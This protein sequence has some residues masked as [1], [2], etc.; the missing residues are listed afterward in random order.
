MNTINTNTTVRSDTPVVLKKNTEVCG[1]RFELST[2][3]KGVKDLQKDLKLLDQVKSQ[4]NHEVDLQDILMK[5]KKLPFT[6]HANTG[7]L[8]E[9]DE[10]GILCD[11]TGEPS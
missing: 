3:D 7:E 11:R 2:S 8:E 6:A 4:I 5:M 10:N 1:D 9:A